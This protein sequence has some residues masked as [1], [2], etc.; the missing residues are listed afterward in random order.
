MARPLKIRIIGDRFADAQEILWY[1]PGFSVT[2]LK[3]DPG[4][5][6]TAKLAIDADCELGLHGFRVRTATGISN[7]ITF[8]VGALPEVVKRSRTTSLTTLK[9]LHSIAR[10]TASLKM[11]TSITF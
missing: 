8:S 9:G 2:E 10:S 11:K 1:D 3:A 4:N 5:F 7:L 6:I